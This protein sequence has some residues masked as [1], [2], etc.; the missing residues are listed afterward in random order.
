[1]AKGLKKTKAKIEANGGTTRNIDS[2]L[3]LA[4]QKY[5]AIKK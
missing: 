3:D 5:L 1:M 4:T 2:L